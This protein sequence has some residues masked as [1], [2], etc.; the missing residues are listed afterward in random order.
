MCER[1]GNLVQI[2]KSGVAHTTMPAGAGNVH[3]CPP[4]MSISLR[5]TGEIM[6]HFRFAHAAEQVVIAFAVN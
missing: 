6:R 5:S 4:E 2:R 3:V 1:P